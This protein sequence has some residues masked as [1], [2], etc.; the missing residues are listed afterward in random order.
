MTLISDST[1]N[2]K[3]QKGGE[4]SQVNCNMAVAGLLLQTVSLTWYCIMLNCIND[5]MPVS[6]L[7]SNK[8]LSNFKIKFYFIIYN[9]T[10]VLRDAIS[11]Y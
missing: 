5:K 11:M 6:V 4:R 3:Y 2:K 7:G 9:Y 10:D 8:C 1:A